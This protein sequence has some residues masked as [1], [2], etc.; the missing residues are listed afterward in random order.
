MKS[1]LHII[2]S[3]IGLVIAVW[4]LILGIQ[5]WEVIYF[6][7]AVLWTIFSIRQFNFFLENKFEN[8]QNNT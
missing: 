7:L 1:K 4:N 3:I 2:N 5:R 8:T 6:V